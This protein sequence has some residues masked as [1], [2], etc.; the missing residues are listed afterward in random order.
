ML[1]FATDRWGPTCVCQAGNLAG[2][3]P[4]VA[5]LLIAVGRDRQLLA[6]MRLRCRPADQQDRSEL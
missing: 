4:F 5:Y 6:E 3:K 2:C 1:T